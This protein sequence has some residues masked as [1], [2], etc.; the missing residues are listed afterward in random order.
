[1]TS[2]SDCLPLPIPKI[3]R[4]IRAEAGL[5]EEVGTLEPENPDLQGLWVAQCEA[6]L[7]LAPG[8]GTE[9][10]KPCL[11]FLSGTW[12]FNPPPLDTDKEW[13]RGWKEISIL[14]CIPQSLLHSNYVQS[15]R[16]KA[17][18]LDTSMENQRHF[19]MTFSGMLGTPVAY[20][21]I[22][23]GTTEPVKE[24]PGD[25]HTHYLFCK[26]QWKEKTVSC[27]WNVADTI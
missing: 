2:A 16:A 22:A 20:R 26:G 10:S 13:A 27:K 14:S 19:S 9:G 25:G 21:H 6:S 15:K 7:Q 5:E 18:F 8:T 3:I 12:A 1:M 23:Q 11:S 24:F 17:A 4:K